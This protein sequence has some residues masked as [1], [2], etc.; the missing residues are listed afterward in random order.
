MP[1]LARISI[2]NNYIF[3]YRYH[4][5]HEIRH[6]QSSCLLTKPYVPTSSLV[7]MQYS[8]Q[9]KHYLLHLCSLKLYAV[10]DILIFKGSGIMIS[11]KPFWN[12][13]KKKGISTYALEN[14]Y[15]LNPS[16]ISRLKNNHNFTL[17]TLNRLCD[18]FECDIVDVIIYLP[19]S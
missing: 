1:S 19:D 6:S 13:M 8:W 14:T 11:T 18:L 10:S 9:V 5:L 15:N 7:N 16:E 17:K 4:L 2:S 12:Q 3:S